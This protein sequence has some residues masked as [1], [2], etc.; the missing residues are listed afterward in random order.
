MGLGLGLGAH[1]ARH[2]GDLVVRAHEAVLYP[3][4]L[5]VRHLVRV[6]VRV[7]V[8]VRVWVRVRVRVRISEP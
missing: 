8:W 2:L 3:A 5:D 7:R 1:L 4:D 6:R